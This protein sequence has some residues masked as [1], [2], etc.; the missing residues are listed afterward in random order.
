MQ[1][2]TFSIQVLFLLVRLGLSCPVLLLIS[3][4]LYI[5]YFNFIQMCYYL[6]DKYLTQLCC[7][8]L[9]CFHFGLKPLIWVLNTI[10]PQLRCQKSVVGYYEPFCTNVPQTKCQEFCKFKNKLFMRIFK[11]DHVTTTAT[12]MLCTIW[13][14]YKWLVFV[15]ITYYKGLNSWPY[16][17][18]LVTV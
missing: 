18:S 6:L 14:G 17:F 4:V 10:H 11:W 2:W 15:S 3:V 9:L 12:T 8:S 7:L 16:H 13:S 5:L 1:G